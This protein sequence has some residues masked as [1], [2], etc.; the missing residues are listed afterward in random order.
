MVQLICF[1]VV[2]DDRHVIGATGHDWKRVLQARVG[3][4]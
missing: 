4:R 1:I 2:S 3:W